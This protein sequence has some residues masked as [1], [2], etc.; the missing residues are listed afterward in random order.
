MNISELNRYLAAS[1]TIL[2]TWEQPE[3]PRR[4][5]P[6]PAGIKATR[7]EIDT[8]VMLWIAAGVSCHQAETIATAHMHGNTQL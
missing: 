3:D 8:R 7:V 2:T 4:G 1:R 5:S 6:V